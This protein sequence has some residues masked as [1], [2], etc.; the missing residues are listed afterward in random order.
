MTKQNSDFEGLWESL[1]F[2][3]GVKPR[4]LRYASSALL[5][6]DAGV[7]ANLVAWNR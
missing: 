7:D 6:S 5:F 4:L 2:D 1:H 3:A